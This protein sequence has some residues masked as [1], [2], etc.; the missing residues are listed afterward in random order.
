MAMLNNQMVV[1]FW[2]PRSFVG[3]GME[4]Q[5]KNAIKHFVSEAVVKLEPPKNLEDHLT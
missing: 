5:A 2:I 1:F 3:D 4:T